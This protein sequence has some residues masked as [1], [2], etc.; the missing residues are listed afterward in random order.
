MKRSTVDVWRSVRR[1]KTNL[2]PLAVSLWLLALV[3]S[4]NRGVTAALVDAVPSLPLLCC[5]VLS[6]V[7]AF[8]VS[9]RV[10]STLSLL[11]CRLRVLSCSLRSLS[12]VR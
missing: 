12:T 6:P 10:A 8:V 5:V 9:L 11:S 4:C 2:A 7:A 1:C 3:H